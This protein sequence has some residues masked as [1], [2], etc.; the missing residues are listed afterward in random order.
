MRLAHPEA[1]QPLP[2][3][4]RTTSTHEA[5]KDIRIVRRDSA[6]ENRRVLPAVPVAEA[7]KVHLAACAGRTLLVAVGMVAFFA[8][9]G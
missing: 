1:S 2:E 6:R 9:D 8:L 5:G 7:L 4:R 3:R